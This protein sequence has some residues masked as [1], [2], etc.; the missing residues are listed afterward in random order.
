M[1][2]RQG[3]KAVADDRNEREVLGR[4][5]ADELHE[6]DS[7]ADPDDR[8]GDHR[9][10]VAGP[11]PEDGPRRTHG[12]RRLADAVDALHAHRRRALALR[13]RRSTAALTAHP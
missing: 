1:S 2:A 8:L 12:P 4:H 7:D 13:A 11:A 3:L 10:A 6:I 5:W 9:V